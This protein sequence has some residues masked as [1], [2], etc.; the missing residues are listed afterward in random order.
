MSILIGQISYLPNT[1]VRTKRFEAAQFQ[2]DF[3]HKLLPNA[4]I[5]S[6]AQSYNDSECVYDYVDYI[7]YENGIGAGAARNVILEMFYKSDYD[8][9]LLLDDDTVF[10]DHY[11]PTTFICEVANNERKFK[12]IDAVSAV[13]PEYYPYKK[14]NYEDK[15]NLTHYKFTPRVLNSGSATSIIRNIKKYY[16]KTI[17]YSN[18]DA[19]KGEGREDIEFLIAWLKCG[20]NWYTMQT[21]IRKSLCFDKSS[22]F[23]SDTKKRDEILMHD[24]DVLCDRYKDDG[25]THDVKGKITWKKFNERY[26]KSEDVVYIQRAIPIEY[27]EATTPKRKYTSKKLFEI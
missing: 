24:L 7:R 27:T 19:N 13:E 23:G 21:L 20:F 8:W 15:A 4:K 6:V 9:L 5:I 16:G 22:I 26:N 10:Y 18:V 2:I 3:M 12:N 11:S 25:I 17:Y 1:D 14:L